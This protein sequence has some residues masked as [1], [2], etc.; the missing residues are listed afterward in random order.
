M[1]TCRCLLIGGP[2][3]GKTLN[4]KTPTGTLLFPEASNSL[5]DVLYHRTYCLANS[6]RVLVYAI[7]G[8]STED[9][10]NSIRSLPDD[11]FVDIFMMMNDPRVVPIDIKSDDIG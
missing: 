1:M 6:K 8:M 3:H 11:V 4:V 7:A 5:N 2:G 10:E 9:I